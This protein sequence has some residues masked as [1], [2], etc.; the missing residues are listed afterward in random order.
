MLM[1]CVVMSYELRIAM[2]MVW[3]CPEI[4]DRP[5]LETTKPSNKTLP[6][7]KAANEVAM[8]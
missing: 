8:K 6:S 1:P 2:V 3:V 7:G 5:K 4:K